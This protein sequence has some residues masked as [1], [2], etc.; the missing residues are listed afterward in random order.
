MRGSMELEAAPAARA[1]V[2]VPQVDSQ[3]PAQLQGL[4][5][6]TALLV[7]LVGTVPLA[8]P[9]ANVQVA[10]LQVDTQRP[11]QLLDRVRSIALSVVWASTST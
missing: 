5:R 11:G 4:L 6:R 8:E 3:G 1:L 10:V 9:R 7:M 2:T